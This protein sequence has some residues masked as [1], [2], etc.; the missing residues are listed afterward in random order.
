MRLSSG[1]HYKCLIRVLVQ[2]KYGPVHVIRL[3]LLIREPSK[4]EQ[5]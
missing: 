2:I 3:E 1:V 5:G 4:A